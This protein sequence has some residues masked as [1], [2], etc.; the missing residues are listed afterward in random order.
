[1]IK[2]AVKLAFD[3]A[4]LLAFGTCV[5]AQGAA[6]KVAVHIEKYAELT[7]G[8]DIPEI[9]REGIKT[10]YPGVG[11]V[12]AFVVIYDYEEVKGAAFGLSWPE[13]W[14]EPR[15]QD[16]GS[17]RIGNMR[18]PGD[19]TSVV[20]EE[21]FRGGGPFV[22]GWLSIT[23]TTPGNIE[24]IASETEGAVAI[25][26]CNDVSPGVSEVMFS[27]RGGAGGAK[28]TDPSR[29]L[30]MKNRTLY[31]R[32][33]STGDAP[34]ISQAIKQAIPGDT[35]AVSQGMYRETVY[36]R[37]GVA[38][39]GSYNSDFTERDLISFPSVIRPHEGHACVV[40][41]LSEDSTCAVDGFV[42]TGGHGN[43]GGGMVLRSGSS[44][45]LRNLIIYGNHANLGGGIF[46]HACSPVIEDVL[47]IANEA[48]SGAGIACNMGASPRII[49][50]TIAA[51]TADVG[52][53]IYAKA[54]AP[55]VEKSIIAH[56]RRGAGIHCDDEGSR[57]TFAC[58]DLWDNGTSD[59]GGRAVSGMGLRD[60]IFEDP[61][62]AHVENL[63][64][65][66]SHESPCR[67][68]DNCGKIGSQWTGVPEE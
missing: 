56:N 41:G 14:R 26:D 7:C 53:G 21:C 4:V 42:L 36:L 17:M 19:R 52:S 38:L 48:K 15:W 3:V 37:N 61:M 18:Q 32:P 57:V 25:V 20:F 28:G 30:D 33:D 68:V 54:A 51:N 31:V 27:A 10:T 6:P 29:F 45:T 50:A 8:E 63:N 5:A 67:D 13:T 9:T 23:V 39:V 55:Y 46:C 49:K 1:M 47:I 11:K 16:C 62:F 64:F 24:V 59:F 34:T 22:V 35:V 43:Y 40:G 65:A 66:L 58:C 60:N 44:P 2:W 12:N